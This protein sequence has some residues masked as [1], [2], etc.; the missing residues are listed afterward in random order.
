MERELVKR[1]CLA[2]LLAGP[3][4][5]W[6]GSHIEVKHAT[7]IMSQHQEHVQDLEADGCNGEK[8][9]RDDLREMVFQK[10]SPGLR[11]RFTA[12]DHVLGD[13]TFADVDAEL[14]V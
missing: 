1:K 3:L 14:D 5:S 9:D 4:C 12:A 13:A 10:G 2:Q 8:I 7:A 11:R 6:V